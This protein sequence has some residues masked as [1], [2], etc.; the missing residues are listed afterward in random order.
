MGGER[1]RQS[2]ELLVEQL[3]E[4]P[5]NKKHLRRFP[6]ALEEASRIVE[7][8]PEIKKAELFH[9]ATKGKSSRPKIDTHASRYQAHAKEDD[10][11]GT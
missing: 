4:L 2:A 7:E 9:R 3:T 1:P 5:I 10:L 11:K 8:E 6:G